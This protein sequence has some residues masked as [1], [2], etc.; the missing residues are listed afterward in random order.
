MIGRTDATE[1]FHAVADSADVR[2]SFRWMTDDLA[3]RT[4]LSATP[5]RY[6]D[7]KTVWNVGG[8]L[9]SGLCRVVS[10]FEASFVTNIGIRRI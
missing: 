3:V 5:V 9:V 7:Q 6:F 4:G 8:S 10:G 2:L 1:R